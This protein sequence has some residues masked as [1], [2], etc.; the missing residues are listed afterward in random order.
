MEQVKG[1]IQS[2]IYKNSDT[3]YTVLSISYEGAE[4]VLT[5]HTD[6]VSAGE[7]IEA[8]G[9]F[10]EHALYGR[11][12]RIERYRILPPDDLIS[13]AR[14]LGSGAIKGVGMTLAQRIVDRFKEDTFDIIDDQPERLA[15][16]KGIRDRMAREIYAQYSE[17][18]EMRS[19]V[20]FMEKYG[21]SNKYAV[22]LYDRYGSEI[23]D[24]IKENPYR[25]ADDIKGI[26][27]KT[28]DDIARKAGV[29]LHSQFRIR[30]GIIYTLQ[31]AVS[32]GHTYLPMDILMRACE[33][34]LSVRAFNEN[35]Y[36][37]ANWVRQSEIEEQ[38]MPLVM[39]KKLV[40]SNIDGR[41]AAYPAAFYYYETA[42]AHMLNT[43]NMSCE[44][45]AGK[46]DKRIKGIEESLEITLDEKQKEAVRAS[47]QTNVLVITGGPGTGK[48][49]I[50]NAII[51]LFEL[52]RK[53]VLLAAPT[54]RAAKRMS[55]AT[56]CE[57][58]TIH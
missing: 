56:G 24:I 53:T 9:E 8:E 28:A 1:T 37:D 46:L 17:K 41:T 48:T 43:L 55:Q 47:A 18:R 54:G 16:V 7:I 40:V 21:I 10:S 14:Y 22:Q 49:T 6:H 13:I 34:L 19:A 38:V 20:M 30:S 32:E 50:I 12:F 26:G 58:K 39:E 44:A 2:I 31:R 5:G 11:Q 15:E 29:P 57:A 35:E 23:Y 33:T 25:L 42:V 52:E 45:N 36:D 51:K 27:F 3:M 4:L